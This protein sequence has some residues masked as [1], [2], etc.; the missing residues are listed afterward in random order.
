MDIKRREELDNELYPSPEQAQQETEEL[1][2]TFGISEWNVEFK[3]LRA[4]LYSQFGG[5]K[6]L[7]V[8]QKLKIDNLCR[9]FAMMRRSV[10]KKTTKEFVD[11]MKEARATIESLESTQKIKDL[12]NIPADLLPLTNEDIS[13]IRAGRRWQEMSEKEQDEDI[14]R[15]ERLMPRPRGYWKSFL[16]GG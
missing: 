3:S 12:G 11:L 9:V 7:S 1:L 14:K 4:K 6:K 5:E 13:Q 16:I 2:S 8:T 15:L 10:K